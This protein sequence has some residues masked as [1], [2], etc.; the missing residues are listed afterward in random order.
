MLNN[1]QI[2]AV[3]HFYG[4]CLTLAGPG[5]GKTTVLVKRLVSL[6]ENGVDPKSILVIT[7]TRDAAREMEERFRNSVGAG[8]YP[9]VFG[10]FHSVFLQI[11]K[12][13]LNYSKASLARGSSINALYKEAASLAGL[14]DFPDQLLLRKAVGYYKNTGKIPE[15]LSGMMEP[16]VFMEFLEV[17]DKR[18][19]EQGFMEFDDILVRTR[20]LL[21]GDEKV[22]DYW[23]S[24][25]SFFLV[26]EMQDINA[27]QFEVLKLLVKDNP[28][29]EN[30][31]AV[32][33]DDQSIY[34][35]RGS[36]PGFMLSFPKEFPK[37][38]EIV[39]DTNYR[40]GRKIVECSK[41]LINYNKIR[42]FKDYKAN[43]EIEG[44]VEVSCFEGV[45]QEDKFICDLILGES[46]GGSCENGVGSTAILFRNRSMGNRISRALKQAGIEYFSDEPEYDIRRTPEFLDILAFFRLSIGKGSRKDFIRIMN[47]P[48]RGFGRGGL[49][50]KEFS[51]DS[52]VSYYPKGSDQRKLAVDFAADIKMI[53]GFSPF[54]AVSF[55]NKGLGYESYLRKQNNGADGASIM[56]EILSMAKEFDSIL[57]FIKANEV[58]EQEGVKKEPGEENVFLYTFHGS[59]G[60]E[61]DRVFILD[62]NEGVTPSLS[63]VESGE[64]EEERRM[65]YVAMTRAKHE[66]IICVPGRAGDK[67]LYPSRFVE[68]MG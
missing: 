53:G 7:F 50:G 38:R 56:E 65:F 66:L 64:V 47:K 43:S 8:N 28:N 68:E 40:S 51:F 49:E 32:G 42:F 19:M 35:F 13:D 63:S 39:L 9:V 62:A 29:G 54:L 23:Q 61:F 41:N 11:L 4:P 67:K 27:V 36:D 45:E 60:L 26:D 33:D 30:L 21:S 16:Q 34:G 15:E 31:F 55:I 57:E 25:F 24:R 52:W 2:N 6:I 20:E 12:K 1:N 22:R 10:T 37:T 46:F 17:L 58:E 18:K 14:S 48:E 3:N 44:K 59:K 5:S